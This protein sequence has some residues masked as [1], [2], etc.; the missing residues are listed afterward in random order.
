MIFLELD[1][2]IVCILPWYNQSSS[3]LYGR[4]P[5]TSVYCMYY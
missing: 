4:Y 3:F 2:N 1:D 5:F